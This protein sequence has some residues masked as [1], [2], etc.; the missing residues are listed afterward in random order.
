MLLHMA[1]S[2]LPSRITSLS[3]LERAR[4]QDPEAWSRLVHLY[5]PLI[6]SWTRRAGVGEKDMADL[7]QD[8]WQAVAASFDRFRR[9]SPGDSFRGWLRII[10]TNKVR[11]YWRKL[12]D[13]PVAT[14]GTTAHQLIQSAPEPESS[15]ETGVEH[16]DL[17]HRALELIRPEFEERTWN[18]FWRL[19]VDGRPAADVGR[20]CGLTANAV[21]QARFRVLRRL[22]EE[23]DGI[24]DL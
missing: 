20:E 7:V 6:F 18:A 1:D 4:E 9:D 23:L 15:E 12:H 10:T 22:R 21:H 17:L 19:I 16:H 5:T 14:G 8:V 13:T 24:I 11:D 2:R 3:L